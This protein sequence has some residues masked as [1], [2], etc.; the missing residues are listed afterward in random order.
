MCCVPFLIVY[1]RRVAA[2][3]LLFMGEMRPK[4]TY[5]ITAG[6]KAGRSTDLAC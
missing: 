2:L 5:L 4:C 6:G 1:R 3:P